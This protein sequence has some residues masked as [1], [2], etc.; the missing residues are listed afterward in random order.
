M[1]FY[2]KD[3]ENEFKADVFQEGSQNFIMIDDQKVEFFLRT[4][5]SKTFYSFDNN[6]WKL[7]ISNNNGRKFIY[8]NKDLNVY[9]GFLPSGGEGEGLGSLVTQMP[10]KV[11]KVLVDV[12]QEVKKGETL[13]LL[14]AMKMENEIKSGLDAVVKSVHVKAGESIDSGHLMIELET[15][16]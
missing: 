6:K 14:E 4:I 2:L 15:Q 5:S 9:K 10:G 13:L 8:K 12:G 7:L 1:R 16:E 3:S 11:V